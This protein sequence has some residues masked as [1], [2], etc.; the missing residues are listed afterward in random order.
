MIAPTVK[1]ELSALQGC[2]EFLFF[3]TLCSLRELLTVRAPYLLQTQ[4]KATQPVHTSLPPLCQHA[5]RA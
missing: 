3:L 5:T 2:I 4:W 1:L